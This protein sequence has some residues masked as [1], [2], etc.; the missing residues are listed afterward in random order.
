MQTENK[1]IRKVYLTI[2]TTATDCGS[3]WNLE[4]PDFKNTSEVII[5]WAS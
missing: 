4:L 2:Q 5:T 1:K 3:Y